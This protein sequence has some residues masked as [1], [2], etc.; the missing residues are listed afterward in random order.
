M[1]KPSKKLFSKFGSDAGKAPGVYYSGLGT[2]G[3]VTPQQEIPV[4][5]T[6]EFVIPLNNKKNNKY[7]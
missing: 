4:N 1:C 3:D 6:F 5:F 7:F 2:G